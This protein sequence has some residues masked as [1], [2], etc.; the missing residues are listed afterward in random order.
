MSIQDRKQDHIELCLNEDVTSLETGFWDDLA[1]PHCACPDLS[2]KDISLQTTF[3]KQNYQAPL[4][5]SSMTGGTAQGLE[6]NLRLAQLSGEMQIP[7]GV[8]SQR[9]AI[10]S[11][12]QANDFAQLKKSHPRARLWANLGLVQLNYGVTIEDIKRICNDIEAEALIFHL[13][14]LQEALQP[15]GDTNFSGLW[16]KFEVVRNALEIPIII[17]ETGCG[18][19]VR[20]AKQ[21]VELGADAI[22]VAGMGG[23]HWGYIEGLRQN[24][25]LNMADVF[26]DWG[27]PTPE[28]LVHIHNQFPQLPLIASGGIR[29]GVDA[30]KAIYLGADM[31]G[32]ARPLFT[33]AAR[34]FE[35]LQNFYHHLQN[36]LRIALF[37]TNSTTASDLKNRHDKEIV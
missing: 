36:T 29:H 16:Q 25:E 32:I 34:S 19:D 15:E 4:L 24:S 18:I 13:N 10:E 26:R 20:S 9:I 14:P 5:I 17:K 11:K 2:L 37:C 6:I 30:A 23:T 27:I 12:T 35:D 21:F 1:L 3:L 22:D 7:M 31:V 33:A 28:S 8:G